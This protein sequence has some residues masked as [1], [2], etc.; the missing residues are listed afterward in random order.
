MSSFIAGAPD[1]S[2]LDKGVRVGKQAQISLA[3]PPR[4]LLKVDEAASALNL[5]RAGFI[6]M[7]LS[8]AV[9]KN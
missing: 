7:C 1:G 9:E 8:R 3:M 4:L 2:K 5:T 6:K